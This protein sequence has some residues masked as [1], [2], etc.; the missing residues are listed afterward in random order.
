M[1]SDYWEATPAGGGKI[2]AI[3]ECEIGWTNNQL[4]GNVRDS[5]S[6]HAE[7]GL[8]IAVYGRYATISMVQSDISKLCTQKMREMALHFGRPDMVMKRLLGLDAAF[9]EKEAQHAAKESRALGRKGGGLRRNAKS[10]G[11]SL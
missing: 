5:E 2:E 4:R 1:P 8:L 9:A 11:R 10:S 6:V 3:R 7:I